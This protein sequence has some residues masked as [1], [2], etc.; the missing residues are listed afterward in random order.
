[1]LNLKKLSGDDVV[2]FTAF[3]PI[4]GGSNLGRAEFHFCPIWKRGKLQRFFIYPKQ[5]REQKFYYEVETAQSHLFSVGSLTH[6][7][8]ELPYIWT[9]YWC[10]EHKCMTLN[11]YVPRNSNCFRVCTLTTMA[12]VNF[13]FRETS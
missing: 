3:D 5:Q 10:P 1:M 13:D 6:K 4:P 8:I 2:Y 11:V 12:G 9:H 7:G